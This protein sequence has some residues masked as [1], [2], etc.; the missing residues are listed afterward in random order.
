MSEPRK[1]DFGAPKAQ[2]VATPVQAQ[3]TFI[4]NPVVT[5][6]PAPVANIVPAQTGND[7]SLV[8][9]APRQPTS[10]LTLTDVNSYGAASMQRLGSVNENILKFAKG[11]MLDEAGAGLGQLL[12]ASEQYSPKNLGKTKGLLFKAKLTF[13][14]LRTN[15]DSVHTQVEQLAKKV[16]IT[17]QNLHRQVGDLEKLFNGAKQNYH[18]LIAEIDKL[19][20][21]IA[22]EE[23]Y[24]PVFDASD[25]FSSTEYQKWQSLIA[26]ARN[27]S[28]DLKRQ[29]MVTAQNGVIITMMATNSMALIQKFN[30]VTTFTIP[31][32]KTTFV[33]M[34][35]QMQQKQAVELQKKIDET[36]SKAL[37]ANGQLL[38]DNTK[39]VQEQLAKSIVSIEDLQFTNDAI[40]RAVEDTKNIQQAMKDR[41]I[42]E[43]P[44]LEAMEQQLRQIQVK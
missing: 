16:D 30:G 24:P 44:Q 42:A 10:R 32:L 3:P 38:M 33:M 34:V 29:K 11:S 41:I 27:R 31:Q 5:P 14:Q 40:M 22:D 39:A 35:E 4:E 8:G 36:N 23:A 43:R 13:A 9:Y 21:R 17:V 20:K 7:T 19:D 26:T 28:E 1:I 6:S 18:E 37:R 12:V 2:P 25:P 15:F